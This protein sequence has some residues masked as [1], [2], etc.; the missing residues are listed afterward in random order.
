MTTGAQSSDRRPLDWATRYEI[1]VGDDRHH[2]VCRACGV[3]ADVPGTVGDDPCLGAADAS[4]FEIDEA[5]VTFW[6][7]CPSCAA[8]R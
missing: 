8:A 7:L 2:L 6:G 1:R 3:A 5:V 4:G